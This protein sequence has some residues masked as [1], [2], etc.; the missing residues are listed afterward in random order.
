MYVLIVQRINEC[1][2][3]SNITK[4]SRTCTIESVGEFKLKEFKN[5]TSSAKCF[6]HNKPSKRHYKQLRKGTAVVCTCTSFVT[7]LNISLPSK[8]GGVLL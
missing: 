2:N 4:F 1:A 3:R 6:A 5:I 8:G 7:A